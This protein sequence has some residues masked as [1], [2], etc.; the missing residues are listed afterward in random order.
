MNNEGTVTISLARHKELEEFERIYNLGKDHTI[1]IE[2]SHDE[3]V[4]HSV[5]YH[6]LEIRTDSDALKE[7]ADKL[8]ASNNECK[9]LLKKI[10]TYQSMLKLWRDFQTD[11][12]KYS[13][14]QFLVERKKFRTY[15]Y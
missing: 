8:K 15:P 5:H 14:W 1:I 12:S 6:N 9:E 7:L 11:L 13:I 3:T 4:K 10:Q 2:I